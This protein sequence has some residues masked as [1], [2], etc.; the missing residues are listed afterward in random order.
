MNTFLH[1]VCE[2]LY[3][4]VIALAIAMVIHIFF[5][6]PTRVSGESMMPTLKN[7]EYLIVS[8]W[9]HVMGEVPN[10]GDI[11]IIDSRVQYP[12]TWKDDVAE[13][14]N[15]YLA[16]FDHDLQT[17]NVWV[18]RVIG[19]PGDTLAFH[20][21]KVWRNGEPL[22]EPYINGPMEYSSREEVKVPEGYVFC[23]GDNR[24]HSSDSRFIG[25]VPIDHVLGRVIW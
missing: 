2:W 25:P 3:S 4:I 12:R 5:F 15:N 7:G 19:R 16:F 10:Y 18:K 20:D 8:K 21:V 9:S 17:K 13:P 1:E 6:Q 14:M 11:V 24:N 22:D 23:M